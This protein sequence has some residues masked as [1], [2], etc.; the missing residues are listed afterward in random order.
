[1]KTVNT[2]SLGVKV[3]LANLYVKMGRLDDAEKCYLNTYWEFVNTGDTTASYFYNCL[4]N[5]IL[6]Y[7]KMKPRE[8]MIPW[9][10]RNAEMKKSR[11]GRDTENYL[12]AL[13]SITDLMREFKKHKEAEPYF[14][15]QS[16][17]SEK[18]EKG[19]VNY[20]G[21]LVNQG[22]NFIYSGRFEKA[23]IVLIEA[24]KMFEK[25]NLTT[26][27]YYA[28]C[29]SSIG[30]IYLAKEEVDMGIGYLNQAKE[31]YERY[32]HLV[33]NYTFC[34]QNILDFLPDSS[35]VQRLAL[36]KRIIDLLRS[37]N[38]TLNVEYAELLNSAALLNDKLGNIKNSI[39]Y[40][41]RAIYLYE[42]LG[43]ESDIRYSGTLVNLAG[44]Y[45]R[46]DQL[47]EAEK[48]YHKALRC[49]EDNNHTN[50]HYYANCIFNMASFYE[51]IGS[52]KAAEDYYYRTINMFD[53]VYSY[54]NENQRI[55]LMNIGGFMLRTG[56]Y[57]LAYEMMR[58][59][60][61]LFV[62]SGDTIS[63]QYAGNVVNLSQLFVL[64]GDSDSALKSL[65]RA[66]YIMEKYGLFNRINYAVCLSLLS[67]ICRETGKTELAIK[68]LEQA[69]RTLEQASGK[70]SKA[71]MNNLY[72]LAWIEEQL[73]QYSEAEESMSESALIGSKL[74]ENAANFMSERE[75]DNYQNETDRNVER[76]CSFISDRARTGVNFDKY[77]GIL[78]NQLLVSKGF[79]QGVAQK[80][81]LDAEKTP[82]LGNLVSDF[83]NLKSKLSAH[84]AGMAS[85]G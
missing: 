40:H 51:K 50:H 77:S 70:I 35:Q 61:S 1:M 25:Y 43:L 7:N 68:T 38:D 59:A 37:N 62:T 57:D 10:I 21:M 29:I 79:L 81:N 66:K 36:N 82:E 13:V 26:H 60:D 32:N 56:K 72:D 73:G 19:S 44:L 34:L 16:E 27:E 71:Y 58:S 49:M 65:L 54:D 74:L 39:P 28:N 45:N 30:N 5:T 4:S 42:I 9:Y 83:R 18:I 64:A 14:Q 53:K 84:Y 11:Y 47:E 8:D 15:E 41:L 80:I 52:F 20:L 69:L 24:K 75:L 55:R 76:L 6:L 63:E 33:P 2:I 12:E 48:F 3:N 67:D 85:E 22:S 78:Y 23:E 17:V 46:R 31:L